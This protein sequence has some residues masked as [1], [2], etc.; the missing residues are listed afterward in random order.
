MSLHH[1]TIA[2][3]VP[4]RRRA[5]FVHGILGTGAN[6]RTVAR[7][8]VDA[9]PGWDAW[10]ADLRGHGRSP[11][12]QPDPSLAAAARDLAA[13]A[14]S[15][16]VPVA[17]LA[18]HSF[19]GKVAL[20]AAPGVASLERVVTIDSPPGRRE[21][22]RD[23]DSALAVIA[24]LRELPPSFPSRSELVPAVRAKGFS[25]T[26]AQWLAMSTEIRDGAI[27]FVYDLDEIEA[28][29]LDYFA[30]DL[31]PLVESTALPV[32]FVIGERSSSWSAEERARAGGLAPRVTVDGLPTS[33]WVHAEDPDGLVRVLLSRVP[34]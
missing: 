33:H 19:G 14:S 31:W 30:A 28:L 9:R 16:D 13:L 4:A 20:A 23:E 32:H 15:S 18:G 17:L 21:P 8:F 6:L 26:L 34:A 5:I 7:R 11:K 3:A 25:E 22:A 1:D 2:G 29:V 27:R 12:S 10:T 24:A